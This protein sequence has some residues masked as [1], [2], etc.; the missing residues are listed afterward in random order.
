MPAN[1]K[2]HYVPRVYLKNFSINDKTINL[3]NLSR[4][5]VIREG[6]LKSQCYRDY[7]YGVED[8]MEKAL[9][10]IEGQAAKLFRDIRREL[11]PPQPGSV[12]FGSFLTFVFF[13]RNRTLYAARALNE[14]FVGMAQKIISYRP[15]IPKDIFEKV[16]IEV[17]EPAVHALVA[18]NQS[19]HFAMDLSCKLLLAKKGSEFITSDN[20]VVFYN[21]ALEA[22]QTHNGLGIASKG[23]QIFFPIS[24]EISILFYDAS[25]YKVGGRREQSVQVT[26]QHDMDQINILT[27][28]NAEENIYFLT[29]DR[30]NLGKIKTGG[31]FRITNTCE[32]HT[33]PGKRTEH[34][35]SDLLIH[36]GIRPKT[37][38]RLS[39]LKELK[40]SEVLRNL[41][42]SGHIRHPGLLR[43]PILV[44]WDN[45]WQKSVEAGNKQN[46]FEY[47]A[48]QQ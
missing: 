18:A 36:Q 7:L 26:E 45:R 41:C 16:S 10:L 31:K 37:G 35:N 42:N 13:Q 15:D 11:K 32:L 21:Q 47:I 25:I 48:S 9:G 22:C 39:F 17:I 8:G 28:A 1:K 46:F 5:I 19:L 23:L 40:T 34:E 14:M 20:P 30:I 43:D 3:Y 2:H 29:S 24:P 4:D 6:K 12:A 44:T 38:L 33:F 27:L